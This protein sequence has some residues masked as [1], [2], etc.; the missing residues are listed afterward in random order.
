MA[1]GGA[2]AGDHAQ[3]EGLVELDGLR[4]SQVLCDQDGGLCALH[5]AGVVAH[6]EIE[7]SGL[8]IDE[9][10]ASGLH[11]GIVHLREHLRIVVKC[12]LGRVLRASLLLGDD[13]A[14]GVLQILVL[15]HHLMCLED[16]GALF[17]RVLQGLLVQD[18]LLVDGLLE[19]VFKALQLLVGILDDAVVDVIDRCL[20]DLDLA[21][22]DA[23]QDTFA[24]CNYHNC[25]SSSLNTSS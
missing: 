10:G 18:A 1:V 4:G 15:E 2:L 5:A 8:D 9:V 6:Q 13:L 14:G 12:G 21:D 23:V 11:V 22:A 17:A 19:G 25:V 7:D 20:V 16:S 24:G 3:Q